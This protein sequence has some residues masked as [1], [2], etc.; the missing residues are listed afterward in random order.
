[1]GGFSDLAN[2]FRVEKPTKRK[3]KEQIL[4]EGLRKLL[5]NSGKCLCTMRESCSSCDNPFRDD[6][7]KLVNDYEGN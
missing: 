2:G 1:M 5:D 6:V 7:R 4:V 3:S